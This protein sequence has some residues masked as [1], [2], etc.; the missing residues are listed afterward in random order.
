MTK[1]KHP[2]QSPQPSLCT[3]SQVVPYLYLTHWPRF[4]ED[5]QIPSG[6]VYAFAYPF[7]DLKSPLAWGTGGSTS[8]PQLLRPELAN[9]AVHQ[10][11]LRIPFHYY[12]VYTHD[13]EGEGC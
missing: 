4:P 1:Q 8:V 2:G 7:P 5:T 10:N 6:H 11:Y 3:S 12:Y 13:V 9:K